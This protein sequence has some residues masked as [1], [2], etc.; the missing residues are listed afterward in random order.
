MLVAV[1]GTTLSAYLYT[2][3]SNEEVEEEKAM[4]RVSIA[5]RRGASNAELQSS[6]RDVLF[7]MF[8]SN[9]AMYFI[10]LAAAATLFKVG[11]TDIASLDIEF[12]QM[13]VYDVAGL[14]EKFDVVIFMGVLYHLRHPLLAL[15]L[16][17]EH[18]ARDMMI[19]QSMQRGS[20][21]V[22]EFDTDYPFW[23]TAVFEKPDYPV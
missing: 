8:F 6:G 21:E 10:I 2:W 9:L 20:R 13:S 15:D 5:E 12:R 11:K 22:S 17:H 16:I 4:G 18:V 3:Q 7:G 14:R 23:E 1:I 19:F